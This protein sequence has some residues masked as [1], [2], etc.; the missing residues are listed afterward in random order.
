M[1][2]RAM[3]FVSLCLLWATAAQHFL[4]G[5]NWCYDALYNDLTESEREPLRKVIVARAL[6]S[7]SSKTPSA[8]GTR[9][10][11]TTRGSVRWP[12]ARARCCSPVRSPRPPIGPSTRANGTSVY[13]GAGWAGRGAS[14]AV[15][16]A[17]RQH[18]PGPVRLRAAAVT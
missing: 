6:Q 12:S 3:P 11:T 2:R 1:R 16:V 15:R 7:G 18:E 17:W 14:P 9:S 5:L 10:A 8:P 13:A 4:R